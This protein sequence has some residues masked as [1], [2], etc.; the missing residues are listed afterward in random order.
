MGIA[1]KGSL[2]GTG[3]S[4]NNQVTLVHTTI[5]TA[6]AKG[7]LIVVVVVDDNSGTADKVADEV[8]G[9]TD[10]AGNV[11]ANVAG[12]SNSVGAAAQS[13]ASVSVWTSIA[14]AALA[15]GG[16]IT[17]TF[18]SATLSDATA[19]VARAFTVDAGAA[20]ALAAAA[21]TLSTDAGQSTSMN[22]T[23][24][25]IQCL[26]IRADGEES[27]SATQ[28]TNTANWTVWDHVRSGSGTSALEVCARVEHRIT[29]GTG[30]ASDPSGE[31]AA[32]RASVYVPL[33]ASW[34]VPYL[35]Q[36]PFPI[37]DRMVA[38]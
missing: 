27:N 6:V 32:D 14:A 28:W 29:T 10:S 25:N 38:Y 24:P 16:T 9:V 12:W 5:T 34:L 36:Q 31:P 26:R 35:V 3:N 18:T 8:S 37:P 30:D 33:T 23:T 13:A 11:Y 7:D 15:I 1:D 17:A 2:G 19:L 22:V 20:V 21:S 4:G